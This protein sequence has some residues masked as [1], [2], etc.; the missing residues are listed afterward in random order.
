[1]TPPAWDDPEPGWYA[2]PD[3]IYEERWRDHRGRPTGW[4]RQR[5]WD[6]RCGAPA[7]HTG[8][9][10]GY[11]GTLVWH[12][13]R[14][15]VAG[16]AGGRLDVPVESCLAA[17]I[18][19]TPSLDGGTD[20]RLD[21]VIELGRPASP[22]PGLASIMVSL[23]FPVACRAALDKVAAALRAGIADRD[24]SSPQQAAPPTR[25][26]PYPHTPEP[27]HAEAQP[28]R[29][30][31]HAAPAS[32]DQRL[33]VDAF[34]SMLAEP[35]TGPDEAR[36]RN[37]VRQRGDDPAGGWAEDRSGERPTDAAPP[38]QHTRTP[39]PRLRF[40]RV[41]DNDAWLSFR[42]LASSAEILAP[43]PPGTARA[44]T[45]D[46]PGHAPGR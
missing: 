36:G 16:P 22:P 5:S 1:V 28:T 10:E 27:R 17:E 34:A 30:P 4:V 41:P 38:G 46:E 21:L 32:H 19:E 12:Q 2:D 29:A 45:Y 26:Q 42:P 15:L 24:A 8:F 35:T 9:L 18:A 23:S 40:A 44:P 20:L 37:T 25:P 3:G 11:T 7:D 6:P 31:R 39:L 14:V 33:V 43:E 13:D